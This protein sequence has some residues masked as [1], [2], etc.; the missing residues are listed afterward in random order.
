[1]PFYKPKAAL[2]VF[3]RMLQQVDIA[4]GEESID[5]YVSVGPAES[6]YRNDPATIQNEVVDFSC[7]LNTTTNLPECPSNGTVGGSI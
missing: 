2:A 1:M 4:T 5:G 3:E 7:T 6:T